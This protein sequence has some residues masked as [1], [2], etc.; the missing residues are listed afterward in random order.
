MKKLF[1]ICL[2]IFQC[3]HL[4]AQISVCDSVSYTIVPAQAFSV[5]LDVT[6][7]LSSAIDSM[8]I[9]WSV[10]NTSICYTATGTPAS[11]PNILQTDTVKACYDV[12]I[13]IDSMNYFCNVCDSLLYNGNSW[14]L[15]IS[16]CLDTT[17][18]NY[19]PLA[20]TP[21]SC[22]YSYGCTDLAACNYD[23]SALCDDGS[24]NLPDG[25]T[26]PVAINYDPTATCDDG[27]C[28]YTTA[29]EDLSDI[30]ISE[31]YPNPTKEIVYFDNFT[32]NVEKLII[33]DV[34]GNEVKTIKLFDKG[35]HKVDISGFSKGIYFGNLIMNNKIIISKK[36][37]VR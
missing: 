18:C 27:S 17:A 33:M 2:I 29:I 21:I 23:P 4:N 35:T 32:N 37:I 36:L 19:N 25:C 5:T 1:S 10:C 28:Q 6:P 13:Y 22:N 26:D 24:C 20:T 14:E 9:L 3:L 8:D 30:V 31:F 7:G 11:F 12:Y 16:G 15:L 34:L